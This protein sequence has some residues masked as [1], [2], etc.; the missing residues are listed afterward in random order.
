MP[1]D[2]HKHQLGFLKRDMILS[3]ELNEIRGIVMCPSRQKCKVLLHNA[4]SNVVVF[5][6]VF[7]NCLDVDG[8]RAAAVI[9]QSHP[10]GKMAVSLTG[11]AEPGI[12]Q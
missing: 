7:L 11:R 1:K 12:G 3:S 8:M 4:L 5:V 2:L 9:H 6:Y 10:A